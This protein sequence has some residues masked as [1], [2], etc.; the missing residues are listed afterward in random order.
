[1]PTS[2]CAHNPGSDVALLNAM[3]YVIITEG[4]A[5]KAFIQSRT[6]NFEDCRETVLKY[7]PEKVEGITG[8]PAEKVRQAARLFATAE[9]GATYYTMGITQHTSAWTTC[10]RSPTWP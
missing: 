4:L 2:T 10:S 6:E 1:M 3:M 9:N 5:D 8:V 7:S